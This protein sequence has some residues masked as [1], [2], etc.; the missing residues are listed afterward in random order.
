VEG[1]VQF[2]L[3]LV[4]AAAARCSSSPSSVYGAPWTS[5]GG[6]SSQQGPG[7]REPIERPQGLQP[8]AQRQLHCLTPLPHREMLPASSSGV[9]PTEASGSASSSGGSWGGRS[10]PCLLRARWAEGPAS[11]P[12][13]GRKSCSILAKLRHLVD[14]SRDAD[15]PGRHRCG[16]QRHDG[17]RSWK[18]QPPR[19]HHAPLLHASLKGP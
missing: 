5:T 1:A 19:C 12:H 14:P 9:L 6:R 7:R 11:A 18:D 10:P 8:S 2:S 15:S 13:G 16:C 4:V 17:R 3:R